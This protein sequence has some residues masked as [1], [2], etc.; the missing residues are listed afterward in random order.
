MLFNDSVSVAY[1]YAYGVMN[2]GLVM[3]SD[4]VVVTSFKV[5]FRHLIGGTEQSHENHHNSRQI[6]KICPEYRTST[7][8]C[9]VRSVPP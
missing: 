9:S 8:T 6:T 5:L 7:T 3:K 4:E 1:L 2:G